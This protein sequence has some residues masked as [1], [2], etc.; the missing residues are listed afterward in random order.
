MPPRDSE[1]LDFNQFQKYD[2][3]LCVTYA[4]L[5]LLIEK[6]DGCKTNPEKLSAINIGKH[7][8]SVFSVSAISSLKDIE[9]KH[10]K[11]AQKSLVNP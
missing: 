9:N 5:E 7:I 11:I 1:I 4:D 8:P 10:G 3:T 6:T 2:K